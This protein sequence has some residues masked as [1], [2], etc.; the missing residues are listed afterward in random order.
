M[1]YTTTAEKPRWPFLSKPSNHAYFLVDFL[2]QAPEGPKTRISLRPIIKTHFVSSYGRS[3]PV[4][5]FGYLFRVH[6][7]ASEFFLKQRDKTVHNTRSNN[8]PT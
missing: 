8:L 7:I 4:D 6:T 1:Q 3:V 2:V 5:F